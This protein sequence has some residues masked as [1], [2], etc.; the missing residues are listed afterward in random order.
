MPDP[1]RLEIVYWLLALLGA[2]IPLATFLPWLL[3]HGLNV[4]L[5]VQE[6]FA[7]RSSAFFTLDVVITAIVILVAAFAARRSLS[8]RQMAGV[9]VATLLVG[10]SC[11]LPLLL[12]MLARTKG[13]GVIGT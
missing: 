5:L 4:E 10:A 7:T 12:A 6:L 13:V 1:R 3:E 11:G 8:G 9:V 2:V